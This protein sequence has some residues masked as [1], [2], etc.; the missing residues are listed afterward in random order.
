MKINLI[1]AALALLFSQLLHADSRGITCDGCSSWQMGQAARQATSNGIV[2]VFNAHSGHVNKYQVFS[3]VVDQ[4]PRTSWTSAVKL[5]TEGTLKRAYEDYL[6]A[7]AGMGF[8]G[9]IVLPPDFPV[10]SVAGALVDPVFTSTAIENYLMTLTEQQQLELTLA[11]LASKVLDL[12]LPLVDLRS[13]IQA[14]TLRVEFPDGSWQDYTVD[15]SMNQGELRARTE[16][17]PHG[18]ATAADGLPAPTSALG[19]RNRRFHDRGGSL[20]EWIALARLH[21]VRIG[22]GSGTTMECWIDGNEIYCVVSTSK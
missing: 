12:N 2:Y 20:I 21:G 8:N 6:E 5:T 14:V 19:F 10:R 1:L 11:A 16:L 3:E 17:S 22:G 18:N 13:I 7:V 15:Y 4:T 9:T